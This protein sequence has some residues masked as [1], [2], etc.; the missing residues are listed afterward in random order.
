MK[1]FDG[2]GVEVKARFAQVKGALG[3]PR[4]MDYSKLHAHD[5][6]VDSVATFRFMKKERLEEHSNCGL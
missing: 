2:N 4:L 6:P 3:G 5:A 1:C